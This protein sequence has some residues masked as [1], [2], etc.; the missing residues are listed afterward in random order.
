VC[1][2][3]A[4]RKT[5]LT[6][7][8][9]VADRRLHNQRLEGKPF[10]GPEAAVQWLG[11]VQAQD[12]AGAKWALAQR[13]AGAPTSAAIDRLFDQGRLLRTHVL[14]PTWH[15]VSPQDIRWML[16]LTGP[17]VNA[18]SA[19]YHR[20]LE[21]DG[22]VFRRSGALIA[23][24]LQG[25]ASLTRTELALA[26]Q[27]AGIEASGLRLAYLIMHAELDGI[28]C[29]GPLRGKQLTY[30][31]LDER[32][33]EEGPVLDRDES[34]AELTRRYFESHGPALAQ[35]FAWWSGLT[36]TEARAGIEM[37][38]PGLASETVQGRTFWWSPRAGTAAVEKPA[39]HLLP[40]YDEYIIAYKDHAAS[41]DPSRPRLSRTRADV[42]ALQAH[43]VVL[44]GRVIGGWRRTVAR[45][46]VTV[47]TD[48]LVRL[49]RAEQEALHKAAERYGQFLEMPVTVS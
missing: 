36:T 40:N 19:Y 18:A 4:V 16:R 5:P 28:L 37:A 47:T 27:R 41:F 7:F 3:R 13:T 35:D 24:A 45:N 33:P 6:S 22:T 17:R 32:A 2:P 44:D 11:A 23:R 42:D 39:L 49:T 31:L 38:Q 8:S 9:D 48:L 20:K 26:C 34:L 30:A 12:Y 25:G 46:R 21:L 15:F 14:R 10:E 1:H 29:S 43:I